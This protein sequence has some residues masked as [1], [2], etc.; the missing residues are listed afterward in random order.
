MEKA[1]VSPLTFRDLSE[2]ESYQLLARNHVG[3]IA[4]S[5]QDAVDIRPIH[6]GRSGEW[7]FGRTSPGDKLTK[8]RHNQWVAFEVDEVAGPLDWRSV[9]AHGSFRPLKPEGTAHDLRLFRNASDAILTMY[10][11]AFTDDDQLAFRTEIFGVHIDS[12]S[13]RSCST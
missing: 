6:Y 7:L 5:F 11:A 10:P 12:I 8:L 13:G 9:I 4:F 3:R 2:D 1:S